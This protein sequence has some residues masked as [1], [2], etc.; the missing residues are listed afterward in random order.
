MN[1]TSDPAKRRDFFCLM[2]ILNPLPD[3]QQLSFINWEAH[4]EHKF[5][6]LFFLHDHFFR[7]DLVYFNSGIMADKGP[8]KDLICSLHQMFSKSVVQ[9][10]WMI[11]LFL[12]PKHEST[13]FSHLNVYCIALM[14][15]FS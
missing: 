11:S 10:G 12:Q 4:C 9:S 2:D 15:F 7:S 8:L 13:A 6:S 3:D 1:D 5:K 14:H